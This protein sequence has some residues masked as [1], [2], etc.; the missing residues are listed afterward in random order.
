MADTGHGIEPTVLAHIFEPF[1]TTKAPGKGSGMGLSVV[2]GIT[3]GLGGDILVESTPGEGS[4]FSVYLPAQEIR[5]DVPIQNDASM[6][7]GHEQLLIVDDEEAIVRIASEVLRNLG[8]TVHTI[9]SSVDALQLIRDEP[10]RFDLVLTDLTMPAMTGLQL[11]AEIS[12]LRP[13]LPIVLMT[14]YRETV[15]QEMLEASSVRELLLKPFTMS[16][17]SQLVRHTLDKEDDLQSV[18]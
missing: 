2:Y 9:C 16:T 18:A 4:V 7:R 11:A 5:N 3:H 8:Y 1:F 15:D 14:G 6:P 10:D 13:D 17:L 12:H